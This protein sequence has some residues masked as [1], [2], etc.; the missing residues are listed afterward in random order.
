MTFVL[1]LSCCFD[2]LTRTKVEGIYSH[3]KSQLI[4]ILHANW[5]QLISSHFFPESIFSD[6]I[7]PG[8]FPNR[9]RKTNLRLTTSAEKMSTLQTLPTEIVEQILWDLPMADLLKAQSICTMFRETI[10]HSKSLQESLFFVGTSKPFPPGPWNELQNPLLLAHF[11]GW[12]G[13]RVNY[14]GN[15]VHSFKHLSSHLPE[16]RS[17][18]LPTASW[19]DMLVTQPPCHHIQLYPQVRD[20]L[21][22]GSDQDN[23]FGLGVVGLNIFDCKG[24]TMGQLVY[25]VV[26]CFQKAERTLDN[27]KFLLEEVDWHFHICH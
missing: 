3:L 10:K 21:W 25:W 6:S 23:M 27:V 15:P 17:L 8:R 4:H 7:Q 5:K 26:M 20:D 11:P 13:T 19:R 24:L 1:V 14:F 22:D 2:S 12:K 16:P 18:L 9:N